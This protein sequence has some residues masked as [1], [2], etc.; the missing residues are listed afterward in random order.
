M[1][2]TIYAAAGTT[3]LELPWTEPPLHLNQ[4]MH[5][6]PK[7][8]LTAEVRG[9]ARDLM[10][11]VG[12]LEL[13]RPAVQLVWLVETRHTRDSENIAP[14]LKAICDGLVDGGLAPDD[15][16]KYMH[17]PMPIVAYAR[18]H[19][20]AP[21]MHVVIWDAPGWTDE[22]ERALA[23]LEVSLGIAR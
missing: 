11:R 2:H 7:A 10:L 6:R 13:E 22:E 21:S 18:G 15:A 17:K 14:T 19:R 23:A 8:K 9:T 5:H 4:R 12:P 16:P 3:V 20:K 1:S